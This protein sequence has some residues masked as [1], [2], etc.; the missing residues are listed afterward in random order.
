M[1]LKTIKQVRKD[2][3]FWGLFWQE[4]QLGAGYASTSPTERACETL[5]TKIYT[6]SDLHLFSHS[7]DAIYVPQHIKTIDEA[8]HLLSIEFKKALKDKYIKCKERNDLY[9]L[10]A[11]NKLIALL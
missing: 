11:E 6:S 8:V 1:S 3:E 7:S 9:V 2:L 10:E 4:K 5:R